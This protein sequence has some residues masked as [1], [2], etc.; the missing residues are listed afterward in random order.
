VTLILTFGIASTA[1]AQESASPFSLRAPVLSRG[2]S[3][4]QHWFYR[5]RQPVPQTSKPAPTSP[6]APA[7]ASP[8]Q[9]VRVP[10][11]IP[12]ENG[13]A[14][15]PSTVCSAR[16][17]PMDKGASPSALVRP[18]KGLQNETKFSMRGAEGTCAPQ[19]PAAVIPK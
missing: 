15:T 4:P 12:Y 16:I 19:P 14:R 11:L 7:L 10:A 2:V 1:L 18:P 3:P 6:A 8:P 13:V 17:V 9:D 5:Y